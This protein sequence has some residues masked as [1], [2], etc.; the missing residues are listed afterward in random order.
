MGVNRIE[1]MKAAEIEAAVAV[2][3]VERTLERVAPALA[4]PAVLPP[5]KEASPQVLRPAPKP[6]AKDPDIRRAVIPTMAP[7]IDS[8][9][10][11]T[12]PL[13]RSQTTPRAFR[14][15]SPTIQATRLPSRGTVEPR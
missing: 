10:F 13:I 14:I 7:K 8:K 9:A 4:S 11:L 2:A 3:T 1:R 6:M 12:V 5:R 15:S